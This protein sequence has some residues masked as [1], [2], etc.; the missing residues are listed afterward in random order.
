MSIVIAKRTKNGFVFGA[1]SQCTRGHSTEEVTKIFKS[2]KEDDVYIGVVGSLRDCNILKTATELLDIN[3]IRRD[4]LDED[5]II[6][7]T[8]PKI[9][10]LLEDNGRQL[11]DKEDGVCWNSH[12][13]IVYK[14]KAFEIDHDFTVA[15]IKDFSAIGN[16]M[17]EAKGAYEILRRLNSKLSDYDMVKEI[18]AMTIDVNNTVSYPIRIIDTSKD[19]EFTEINATLV[20]E[21][22]K[23]KEK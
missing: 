17:L 18:I 22:P 20:I 6:L 1:D 15:E 9:R 2:K 13:L 11:A 8:V 3:A 5:S 14:D 19:T 12:I 23:G 21:D 10:K 7:Y 4:N 16:P